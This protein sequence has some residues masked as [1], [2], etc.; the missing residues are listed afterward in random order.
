LKFGEEK[1]PDNTSDPATDVLLRGVVTR[2]TY[3]DAKS[4]FAVLRADAEEAIREAE[5]LQNPITVVGEVADSPAVGVHFIARGRWSTHPKFGKQFRAYSFTEARPTSNEAIEKYLGSGAVKGIGPELA[6]RIVDEFGQDSLRILDEEPQRLQEISGI[7]KKKLIDLKENWESKKNLR[8]ILL[9]FQQHNISLA[10]AH[11]IY[12]TFKDKAIEIVKENPYVLARDVWGIGFHTADKIAL[13]LGVEPAAMSR[14]IAGLSHCL[15]QGIDDGHCYLPTS[16]L[17][18]K[19]SS[20]LAVADEQLLTDALTHSSLQGEIVLS[21]DRVY[22]PQLFQAEQVLAEAIVERLNS[23]AIEKVTIPA[24]I[25]QQAC[26]GTLSNESS[27]VQLSEQ[28]Q[29]AVTL[30]ASRGMVVITGGPGCGKTTVTRAIARLF[31][32]AGLSV[33]LAAPTGRAAQRLAEVCGIEA[34]TIHRLL[35]FDPSGRNFLHDND[36]PLPLDALIVDESSMIDLPLAA[37][38]FKA[39][40]RHARVIV[41]GDADQLPS[42][43]PGLFLSDLLTIKEV[44]RVQLTT[45]FRRADESAITQIAHRINAAVVPDIPEPD[46][47]TKS[48]AY[49]LPALDLQRAAEL[50]EKLVV[51]QIPKKFGYSGSDITVL[52]PMNQGD[53]GIISLNQRLQQRLV[54]PRAGLPT[55]KVGNL[56]FRLGDRVCQRVNNYNLGTSGVFN[57]D[58]GEIIGIDTNSQS[59]TVRLWDGRE[60]TYGSESLYQLDLAYAITIHRSQGSEMP[61]VVLALH[62]SHNILLERQLIYTAIT[63]AKKLLVIVGTKKAL[64]LSTKRTR[65]KR[66]YSTLIDK[67]QEKLR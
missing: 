45:L 55:V 28:Q 8:E 36:D 10:L 15:K 23:E 16:V 26:E 61:V 30:A 59:V 21:Q 19:T 40:P 14:L 13:N 38:L 35:K 2:I 64:A 56:E 60:V 62:E 33:K 46:G 53:L 43:G 65:G 5:N 58:Q 39:L 24:H 57:G 50:I 41:V 18:G 44:P 67:I 1:L 49:F 22:L 37:S 31:V 3:K 12:N 17:L 4:G 66:R 6:K 29:R 27:S 25:V 48:D 20:L 11:R 54:P 63:R 34:A 32:R 42:V 51:E 47:N 7:G 52:S 9:F